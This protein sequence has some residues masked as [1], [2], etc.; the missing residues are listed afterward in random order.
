MVKLTIDGVKIE[1]K[2]GTTVLEAASKAGIYIPTFCNHPKLATIGA[3]RICLVEIEGG[4]RPEASCALVA[5]D[6]MVVYTD[7]PLVKKTRRVNLEALLADHPLDCPHCESGGD[8]DLQ[9]ITY[10]FSGKD[11]RLASIFGPKMPDYKIRYYSP[12]IERDLKKCIHCKRCVRTCRE[13]QGVNAIGLVNRGH[14]TFISSFYEEKLD[15]EFCGRC[16]TLCPVGALITKRTKHKARPWEVKKVKT[17]C[18]YCGNG[19]R[20]NYWV[21]NNEI[22]KVVP[23][24]NEGMN[25]GNSCIRGYFGYEVLFNQDRI[26]EPLVKINKKQTTASWTEA[27]NKVSSIISKAVNKKVSKKI[28][29]ISA[30]RLSI[31]EHYIFQKYI[32]MITGSNNFYTLNRLINYPTI[33]KFEKILGRSSSTVSYNE[34]SNVDMVMTFNSDITENNPTVGNIFKKVY[35]ESKPEIYTFNENNVNIKKFSNYNYHL[36]LEQSTKL[37]KIISA[38]L[39][40]RNKTKLRNKVFGKLELNLLLDELENEKLGA[41][42]KDTGI[43]A[44]ELNNIIKK[45]DSANSLIIVTSLNE[46]TPE[47]SEAISLFLFCSGYDNRQGSGLALL[48]S[49]NNEEGAEEMGFH[50]QLLPGHHRI[51]DFKSAKIFENNWQVSLNPEEGL[52]E[53]TFISELENGEIPVLIYLGGEIPYGHQPISE[54]KKIF[55][56]EKID[57][58]EESVIEFWRKMNK[59]GY[60][61]VLDAFQNQHFNQA[62]VILP[63]STPPEKSGTFMSGER[64][65]QYLSRAINPI[66]KYSSDWRIGLEIAE[67]FNFFNQN[68]N[69]EDIQK[70]IGEIIPYWPKKSFIRNE[71]IEMMILSSKKDILD[72][73][74]LNS[75]K[76]AIS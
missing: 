62:D 76:G 52:K 64:R 66:N 36:N 16:V 15:C 35:L 23:E 3:C 73:E 55:F 19:C 1:V 29:V 14:D 4:R 69:L 67:S 7:T 47:L 50:P 32:R 60:L 31:E 46:I 25:Q 13:I 45:I 58:Y 53:S 6:E 26:V 63:I 18:S 48:K 39:Y 28:A 27:L 12:L 38:E 65:L 21:K 68:R 22:V 2:K 20:F 10:F 51:S 70:E 33:E 37:L 11:N 30:G 71:E 44:T 61:I 34:I 43:K 24:E 8:C 40:E 57:K 9:R 41:L 17:V 56:K 54:F 5:A 49:R 42:A 72:N 59:A 75:N 74:I